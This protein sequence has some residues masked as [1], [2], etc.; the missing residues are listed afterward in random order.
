MSITSGFTSL[1]NSF[2]W[3]YLTVSTFKNWAYIYSFRF[4]H[5]KPGSIRLV[6]RNG[7]QF[8]VKDKNST[9]PIITE[10]WHDKVYG[11]LGEL[12]DKT[13]PVIIDIGGNIGVFS[14]FALSTIPGSMV[15]TFE[16][17]PQNF[18]CLERNI[19]IN[20]MTG[21][22]ITTNKAICGT[23]GE[24]SLFLTAANS[25]TNSMFTTSASASK[26][27][28]SCITLEDI[29]TGFK[30]PAC[31]LLKIDCEGAE[32]EILMQTPKHVFQKIKRIILEWHE[33]PGFTA[34]G[35]QSFLENVGYGVTL[36]HPVANVM[37][38]VQ[39]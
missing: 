9:L 15:Y 28:V 32:Y 19:A 22:C 29:F 23:R 39:K 25:G 36:N 11:D 5:A 17:E 6:L 2:H 37:V 1:K 26:I 24:R 7:I 13:S 21:R 8:E 27:E 3:V 31:D 38:A 30:I 10:I 14:L 12:V 33:V 16:P 34:D 20:A 18:I 35:L 4:S